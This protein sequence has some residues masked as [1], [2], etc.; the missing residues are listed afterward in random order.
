[1]SS[2]WLLL[3]ILLPIL[4]GAASKLVHF[5]K[6][7]A[8]ELFLMLPIT[9]VSVLVWVLILHRPEEGLMLFR[10]TRNLSI[11]LRLDG[12]GAF[13]AAIVATLWPIATIYAFEY[14]RHEER[15]DSFFL[16]YTMTYGITLGITFA[17][18]LL[19][20]YFFYEL[21]TLVTVPLVMFPM[22]RDAVYSARKYLYFS[23]GGTALAFIGLVFIIVY[24]GGDAFLPGG[25]LGLTVGR[26]RT[27]MQVVYLLAFCG[28]GVKAAL[29]PT[30]S[31]LPGAAVAPTP[32]TA[33]LHAV[34]VVKSGVFAIARMTYFS[35]GPTLIAG[36]WAQYAALSIAL[37]TILYGSSIAA[38]E[39]HFKRRLAWSTVS[40]LSYIVFGFL[41]L[42]PEGLG[43]GMMHM[44][45]HAFMKITL[46]YCAGA[47]LHQMGREHVADLD[48]LGRRMTVTF[49][50]YTVSALALTGIPPLSGFYSKFLLGS[51]GI[52]GGSVM[53][54]I[55]LAVLLASALLTAIYALQPAIHA[56]L[57]QNQ[58]PLPSVG[59]RD[60][61]WYML[62]PIVAT[63]L[64]TVLLGVCSDEIFA[65]ISRIA[66]ACF[67]GAL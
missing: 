10:F 51:A 18:N 64:V 29:F 9:A 12:F 61:N 21:L 2:I 16:F 39:R 59:V 35:F 60:P 41:L 37:F 49:V 38:R 3:P 63:T 17:G 52:A 40:N 14:M 31:W 5:R 27:L 36:S 22:T 28:F 50:C 54:V 46:F 23:L 53:G 47:V 30:H 4:C 43:A 8:R 66:A 7:W 45:F 57:P 67:G 33:L 11:T 58:A 32:V 13:F 25:V 42:T 34:A 20:L 19:T 6:K 15:T 26:E 56:F 1:M 44:L 24:G 65:I 55:G 48:G 62:F